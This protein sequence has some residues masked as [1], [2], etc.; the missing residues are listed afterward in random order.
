MSIKLNKDEAGAL[1][2]AVD[3][4][5]RFKRISKERSRELKQWVATLVNASTE[6]KVGES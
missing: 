3:G 6:T 4:L 1:H 2:Y 5:E